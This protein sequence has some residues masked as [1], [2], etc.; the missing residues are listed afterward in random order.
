MYFLYYRQGQH[1]LAQI[2][3][4]QSHLVKFAIFAES[5]MKG[6]LC[7][8]LLHR[9]SVHIPKQV[10]DTLPGAYMREDFGERSIRTTKHKITHAATRDAARASADC[11]LL[12]MCLRRQK[13]MNPDIDEPMARWLAGKK[14]RHTDAGGADGVQLHQLHQAYTG[15]ANDEVCS[16]SWL[17]HYTTHAMYTVR[18]LR[19]RIRLLSNVLCV[20]LSKFLDTLEEMESKMARRAH[21]VQGPYALA[22]VLRREGVAGQRTLTGVTGAA[23]VFWADSASIGQGATVVRTVRGTT[24]RGRTRCDQYAYVPFSS[25]TRHNPC[26]LVVDQ[27][28]LVRK[29]GMGWPGDEAR[30]AVGTLYDHLTIRSGA[31]LEDEWNDDSTVGPHS[32]PRVLFL[33]AKKK[34]RGY[35]WAVHLSQ[36]HCTCSFVQGV[37]GDVFLTSSKMGF[38]GRKDLCLNEDV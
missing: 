24:A 30:L 22:G 31:G 34:R 16:R 35:R 11:C 1:S 4:A 2:R 33:S 13:R 27:L 12:E 3:H 15:A 18:Q 19:D 38:H 26:I 36:V 10:H 6:R 7:S 9:A 21:V 17:S 29:S 23:E 20:Q 32:T 25:A 28:L 5:Q 14:V 37:S 8:L